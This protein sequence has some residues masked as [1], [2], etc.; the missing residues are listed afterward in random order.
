MLPIPVLPASPPPPGAPGVVPA[1][2]SPAADFAALL[3][4]GVAP[5]MPRQRDGEDGNFLP[6]PSGKD[7]EGV[8]PAATN[9][10][11]APPAWLVTCLP[12]ANVSAGAAP[13]ARAAAMT[14]PSSEGSLVPGQL[15]GL[16]APPLTGG[17]TPA[18]LDDAA[19]ATPVGPAAFAWDGPAASAPG[20]EDPAEHR[21]FASP[22]KPPF[23]RHATAAMST[24]VQPGSAS[25]GEAAS[26]PASIPPAATQ[27]A[28]HPVQQA[29]AD[30]LL[31][32]PADASRPALALAPSS[33][34]KQQEY[35]LLARGD[36]PET[37]VTAG[38]GA[39][40]SPT[41]SGTQRGASALHLTP[42]AQMAT[43]APAAQL[44]AAAIHRAVRDERLA[45]TSA[46]LIPGVAPATDLAPHAVAALDAGRHAA[47]DMMREAWPAKMIER[48]EMIRDAID[49]AD[50]SIRLVPDKLGAIDVSLRRD[51]D[52]VMVH[53]NAQQAETRQLLAD[54]QPKLAE[55]AEARGLKL[56]A[57]AGNDPGH[58]QHQQRAP[59]SAPLSTIGQDRAVSHDGSAS[60]DERIA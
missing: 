52:A 55:L 2:A 6:A 15:A 50:T 54:A 39:D 24:P 31:R 14:A 34:G 35:G 42:P 37:P 27:S 13:A 60:A 38:E 36:R 32:Q 10:W 41:P 16:S 40:R 48:I 9:V 22:L 44:F 26:L 1:I 57:Q 18:A 58:Q 19:P 8:D 17:E 3:L 7:E 20:G 45:E 5:V 21:V 28:A 29:P 43:V 51:G 33:A 59:T 4:A 56:S 30:L 23:E 25:R 12:P 11:I 47:L 46:V 49:M 53:L